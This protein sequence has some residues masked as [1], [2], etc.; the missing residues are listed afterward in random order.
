MRALREQREMSLGDLETAS[1][2]SKGYLSQLER[3][4]ATNPSVDAAQKIAV[5][6]GVHVS[7]LLG[8]QPP[9]AG[10][11]KL[12]KGLKEFLNKAA[13]AGSPLPD[14]DVSMLLGIRYR[15]RR[16][17]SAEDWALLYDLIRRI[18]K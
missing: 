17:K 14:Q 9:A 12:P 2:V 7:E 11:H 3:G 10:P 5:G 15:G 18:V 6:L 13:A 4:E 16:P 8:E 1:G